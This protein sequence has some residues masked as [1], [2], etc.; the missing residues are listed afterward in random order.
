MQWIDPLKEAMA[1]HS[2]VLDGFASEAEVMRN[3]GA[4]PSDVMEQVAAYRAECKDRG[5]VFAS[6]FPTPISRRRRHLRPKR[7]QGR[8]I[9]RPR[10]H[11]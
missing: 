10:G 1:W 6:D 4:N 8:V 2:L 5:L 7:R 11:H 9:L 3:R